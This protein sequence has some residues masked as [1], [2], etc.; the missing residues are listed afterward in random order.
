[1]QYDSLES[2]EAK[3]AILDLSK[4]NFS[5][6]QIARITGLSKSSINRFIAK[7]SWKEWWALR[8]EIVPKDNK[9]VKRQMSDQEF[10][11]P[12]VTSNQPPA[13][14]E[15]NTHFV[16]PDTQAKPGVC[17][18][19]MNKIGQYIA[20]RK[21]EV[22]VHLGDH[23]DLPSLSS[24]DKGSR[25]AEGRRL[26]TDLEAGLLSM[27]YLL[28]PIHDLQQ[29]EIE[30]YGEIRYKPY[31]VLTLGNHEQRLERH[32]N[33]NPELFGF[34]DYESFR[35]SEMGWDW[36]DFL[37]PV[38]VDG[39]TYC[40]FMA[41]PFSGKPYGGSCAN[42]L[43]HVGESFTC[44]HKQTLDVTTRFL[45]SSGQQQWGIVAGACYEHLESYKGIQGNKHWRGVVV[46][47]NVKGG[48][49]NPMFVDLDYINRKYKSGFNG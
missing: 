21:P 18:K 29:K 36:Y 5:G 15:G 8:E 40:H 27:E 32:V 24:Y 25:K 6:K 23:Y 1:M 37:D 30:E 16:I 13:K 49:Y 10:R 22:I 44:G 38:I 39:V 35:Y 34:V 17:F 42:I 19:Y 2:E 43:K 3:I 31:M 28:K 48:T 45:P 4:K 26:H 11:F 46:K 47:H 33:A 7:D 14:S 41:N 12:I 20:N 9:V